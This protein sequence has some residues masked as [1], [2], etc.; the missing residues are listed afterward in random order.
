MSESP[1]RFPDVLGEETMGYQLPPPRVL[2]VDDEPM[3]AR[4]IYDLLTERTNY[5]VIVAAGGHDALAKI[6]ASLYTPKDG[7]D[8]VL[9]DITMPVISGLD[10]LQWIR[11]HPG[12]ETL[13][14][15]MLT[16]VDDKHNMINALSQGADDYITK[17]YHSQELLARMSTTLRTQRLEKQLYRQGRQL[18][19]LHVVGTRLTKSLE[20][21]DLLQQGVQGAQKLLEVES[22]CIYMH[23]QAERLLRCRVMASD[24]HRALSAESFPDIAE[25]K[26]VISLAYLNRITQCVNEVETDQRFVPQVDQPPTYKVNNLVVS[27]IFL[28]GH[29]AGVFVALNKKAGSFSHSDVDLFVSLAGTISQAIDN[30]YLFRTLNQRQKELYESTKTLQALIDG[31]LYPI[32]TINQRWQL[33]SINKTKADE[34]KIEAKSLLGEVCYRAFFKREKPCEHCLAAKIIKEQAPRRW[35]VRWVGTDYLPQEWDVNAYPIPN[36][37]GSEARA[38]IFWQD[39][40]EERRMEN[41]LHQAAKLSAVGQ[42]A[43]GVA[44]EINNPLT[45]ITT[46]AEMLKE[47]VPKDATEDYEVVEWIS[48]AAA[49]ATKVVRGLLDFARQ[50]RFY[51][52]EG[53]LVESLEDTIDLVAYQM[54]KSNVQIIKKFSDEL[55]TITASWEHLKTVWLNLLINARDAIKD[56]EWE[57]R[58]IEI[59]ARPAPTNDHVQILFHDNGQGMREEQMVHIFEPFYTTKDPGKGTG[60]GLAT[61]HRIIDQHG[62]EIT[63]TS[64]FGQGTTFVIRLP[65]GEKNGLSEVKEGDSLYYEGNGLGTESAEI[66]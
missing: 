44:H 29:P 23:V 48:K 59:V 50:S 21:Q 1:N 26:G 66:P 28:R 20:V 18:S 53:N 8:L 37:K 51:F 4:S 57:E 55:P 24:E 65:V 2:V 16:G 52:E 22:A 7:I 25:G 30:A 56:K 32:Y 54:K 9:L 58:F 62:G 5:R 6:E 17:P 61:C 46:G 15:V 47:I 35:T 49:R 12:L 38:V 63:V 11:K 36:Y 41:S 45:V 64:Q 27:P 10:V 14:V 43:A 40:T 34:E 42:L 31:I 13:R 60:L 33:V 3:I 39:R 19:M